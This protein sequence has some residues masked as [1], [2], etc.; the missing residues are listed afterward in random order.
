MLNLPCRL[1]NRFGKSVSPW[2]SLDIEDLLGQ[3]RRMTGLTDW[4]DENFQEPLRVLLASYERDALLTLYGRWVTRRSLVRKLVNRLRLQRDFTAHPGILRSSLPPVVMITGLARTGTTLLHRLLAQDPETR[5]LQRWEL[6]LPSPPPERATYAHDPRRGVVRRSG[7]RWER[8]FMSG[9][10][11]R[12]L[13][14]VHPSSHDAPEECWPLLQNAFRSGIFFFFD[15]VT[16]YETW[17][18]D[19]DFDAAYRYYREQLQLLTWKCTGNLLVLKSPT[20]LDQLGSLFSVFP[21]ARILW[22]HRNPVEGMP[23]ACNLVELCRRIKSDCVD[24][25]EIG[26]SLVKSVPRRVGRALAARD[27]SLSGQFLDVS[28]VELVREPLGVVRQVY[29]FLG[30][31]LSEDAECRMEAWLKQNH[32][33]PRRTGPPPSLERYGL[34][35]NSI[36]GAMAEYMARF[37][38][39]L[40]A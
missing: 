40:G 1:V 31:T 12:M 8:L 3:A 27:G 22:T 14:A 29:Q 16:N 15:R 36:H 17:L 11:R 6:Y 26:G 20:H 23:S 19:Q 18:Q 32:P 39:Y 38:P 13:E 2:I 33:G 30:T 35:K 25:E 4:G 5:T 10:G 28:L 7:R 9:E 24:P 21:D 34:S 37:S